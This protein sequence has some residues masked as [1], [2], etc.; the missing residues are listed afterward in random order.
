MSTWEGYWC[1]SI[2][3]V[4]FGRSIRG[5]HIT[6]L[7]A[8]R[9]RQAQEK[10]VAAARTVGLPARTS[11][12]NTSA[13]ITAES[14]RGR[15]GTINSEKPPVSASRAKLNVSQRLTTPNELLEQAELDYQLLLRRKIKAKRKDGGQTGI[16]C[17][18]RRITSDEARGW[19]K[20]I[21]EEERHHRA[22]KRAEMAARHEA[23][24]TD[25]LKR[26]E[27]NQLK[28][29]LIRY[30]VASSEGDGNLMAK[31]ISAARDD[32]D[33][34]LDGGRA[35]K[36]A[37]GRESAMSGRNARPGGRFA[38]G[39]E[40]STE[41]MK[42]KDLVIKAQRRFEL[43]N[44]A[45]L[46]KTFREALENQ[47]SHPDAQTGPTPGQ[48]DETRNMCAYSSSSSPSR[49]TFDPARPN[50]AAETLAEPPSAIASGAED[51]LGRN[52]A[53]AVSAGAP[54]GASPR[55]D[56]R[57]KDYHATAASTSTLP[58]TGN[59]PAIAAVS[60]APPDDSLVRSCASATAESDRQDKKA[61]TS[62]E[63]GKVHVHEVPRAEVLRVL[64]K[65][66]N[67]RRTAMAS[68]AI[69]PILT[70]RN[71]T[72]GEGDVGPCQGERRS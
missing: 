26:G 10:T 24:V 5:R 36:G 65:Q 16:P 12:S 2:S 6:K 42:K 37:P 59:D 64:R 9:K 60:P 25:S 61:H 62:R 56:S 33:Q 34:R 46:R 39:K 38:Y 58:S 23:R 27:R 44:E 7:E 53:A 52:S 15:W 41:E 51:A 29:W 18:Y 71:F 19:Q 30:L 57:G 4:F 68:D 35:G 21:E 1:H 14:G 3:P 48:G 40:V 11:G 22:E 17:P 67:L 28:T 31:A 66:G 69:R 70:D 43:D 20:E 63:E 45:L 54:P 8:A 49:G 32:G 72:K 50:N 47:A 13:A 55:R